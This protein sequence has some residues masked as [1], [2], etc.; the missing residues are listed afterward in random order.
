MIG[1]VV[2]AHFCCTQVCIHVDACLVCIDTRSA[3]YKCT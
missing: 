1:G 2:K 3:V